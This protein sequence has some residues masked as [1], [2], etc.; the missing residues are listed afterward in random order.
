MLDGSLSVFIARPFSIIP[1]VRSSPKLSNLLPKILRLYLARGA[2]VTRIAV[3]YQKIILTVLALK[4]RVLDVCRGPNYRIVRQDR[5]HQIPVHTEDVKVCLVDTASNSAAGF[6]WAMFKDEGMTAEHL[7]LVLQSR[8]EA[9]DA[10]PFAWL[11]VSRCQSL[12][13]RHN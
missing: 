1:S 10:T 9:K 7:H 12:R 4:P 6:G 3:P 2:D 13:S 5:T 11:Q 8:G